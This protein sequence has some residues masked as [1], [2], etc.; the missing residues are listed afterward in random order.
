MLANREKLK[1]LFEHF[2]K[3]HVAYVS[4]LK[5]AIRDPEHTKLYD[6]LETLVTDA[7]KRADEHLEAMRIRQLSSKLQT[8][9]QEFLIAGQQ[10]LRELTELGQLGEKVE[11]L[12]IA[13]SLAK[14]ELDMQKVRD[15]CQY[16][17]Q[18]ESYPEIRKTRHKELSEFELKAKRNITMIKSKISVSRRAS[19]AASRAGSREVS[20]RR[21]IVNIVQDDVDVAGEDDVQDDNIQRSEGEVRPLVQQAAG[22]HDG[23]GEG[24]RS[25]STEGQENEGVN[26]Q[27]A[28]SR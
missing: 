10:I 21:S 2:I 16:I 12:V 18:N 11:A 8:K 17:V 25:S 19:R 13:S 5:A 7:T 23:G 9:S 4:K 24:T 26:A 27:S 15:M 14:A 28:S 3:L 1:E 6:D 22:G 20:S